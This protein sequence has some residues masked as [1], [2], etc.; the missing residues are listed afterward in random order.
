[1]ADHLGAVRSVR[2]GEPASPEKPLG[3]SASLDSCLAVATRLEA[4]MH[5]L[6]TTLYGPHPLGAEPE[7][8]PQSIDSK[9]QGLS[10]V[11]GRL[12]DMVNHLADR[13]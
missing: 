3:V 13:L 12:E 9:V 4:A 10:R 6:E 11:L 1:M 2:R 5:E 8:S 7:D